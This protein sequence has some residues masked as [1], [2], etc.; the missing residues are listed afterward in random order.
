MNVEE[1]IIA[2]EDFGVSIYYLRAGA[3]RS[4]LHSLL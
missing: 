2:L 1:R 3:V 4:S